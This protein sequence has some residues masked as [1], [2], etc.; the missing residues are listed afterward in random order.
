RTNKDRLATTIAR[1]RDKYKTARTIRAMLTPQA[2]RAVISESVYIRPK[3]TTTEKY[4]VVGSSTSK[5]MATL[6]RIRYMTV[7][8]TAGRQRRQPSNQLLHSWQK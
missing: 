5:P 1:G 7:F 4:K 8:P 3:A 6:S 2:D